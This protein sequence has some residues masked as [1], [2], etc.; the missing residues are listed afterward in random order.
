MT[1]NVDVF[2]VGNR[3]RALDEVN[4]P[5]IILHVAQAEK[6]KF[7][8]EYLFRSLQRHLMDAA[9]TEYAFDFYFFGAQ[10]YGFAILSLKLRSQLCCFSS[11]R[12]RSIFN[13]VFARCISSVLEALE[14]WLL[15][16]HDAVGILLIINITH[17]HRRL[18]QS[19]K[20]PA[21]VGPRRR[22]WH[23][24]RAHAMLASLLV[25]RPPGIIF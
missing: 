23:V 5:P 13:Q 15:N 16:C 21:L 24:L 7:P 8:F 11:A 17:V 25:S 1:K 2:S 12:C 4:D 3:M 19:R 9:T 10:K 6:Q 20:I 14:N 18:M 22:H